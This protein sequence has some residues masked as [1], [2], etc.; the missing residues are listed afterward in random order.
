MIKKAQFKLLSNYNDDFRYSSNSGSFFGLINGNR[1]NYCETCRE[2]FSSQFHKKTRRIGWFKTNVNIKNINEFFTKIE[3]S[4]KV[5]K[6]TIFQTT[7]AKDAIVI[8]PSEFWLENLTRRQFFTLFLRGSNY[9]K[10][11][12]IS[13]MNSYDLASK[14]NKPIKHFLGGNT[15]PSYADSKVNDAG[16]LVDLYSGQSDSFISSHLVKKLHPKIHNVEFFPLW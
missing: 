9:Y 4:L 14:I 5:K 10:G 11:N 16:G 13:A 3:K 7:Q 8:E 1:F 15:I 12:V 2:I 6:H